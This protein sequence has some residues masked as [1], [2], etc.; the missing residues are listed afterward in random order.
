MR[1]CIFL[2]KSNNPSQSAFFAGRATGVGTSKPTFLPVYFGHMYK[3]LR[4]SEHACLMSREMRLKLIN[5]LS[6][7]KLRDK[8]NDN[9]GKS[10]FLKR[11]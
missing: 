3:K 8:K 6:L 4:I 9:D 5:C 11:S 1:E 2:V 7:S 10:V